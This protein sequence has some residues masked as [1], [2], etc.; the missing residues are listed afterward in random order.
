MAERAIR[1]VN[2]SKVA[3]PAVPLNFVPSPA[4]YAGGFVFLAARRDNR[5]ATGSVL[6]LDTGIAAR[7]IGRASAGA[8]LVEKYGAAK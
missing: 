6:S 4:D 2:L 8:K 5:A 3:A 1:T 7:G